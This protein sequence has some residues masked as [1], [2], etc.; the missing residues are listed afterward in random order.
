MGRDVPRLESLTIVFSVTFNV[1]RSTLCDLFKDKHTQWTSRN[2]Y[3]TTTKNYEA[4]CIVMT[5]K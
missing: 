2:G 1:Q 5:E 3:T 4:E